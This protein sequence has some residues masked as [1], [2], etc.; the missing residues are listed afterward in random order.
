MDQIPLIKEVMFVGEH[1]TLMTSIVMTE[2]LRE[3]G[4]SDDDLTIRLASESFKALYGW[5]VRANSIDVGVL[6]E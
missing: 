1:F 2:E 6:I 5:D 4:E 3:D